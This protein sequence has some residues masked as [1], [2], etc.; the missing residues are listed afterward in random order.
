MLDPA[1]AHSTDAPEKPP[2][3]PTPG[4]TPGTADSGRPAAEKRS[5]RPV[6]LAV[7]VDGIP[8]ELKTITCWVVWQYIQ[9]IDAET[10]E[11]DYDK[12]PRNARTGGLA[13]STNPKSWSPF[14]VALAAY[15]KEGL[16][17]VGFVLHCRTG[18]DEVIVAIDLDHCRDPQSGAIELWA[19]KVIE[20]I[21]SYTEVSPSGTGIR[22]FLRGRR[23]ERG[24]KKGHVEVYCTARYVTVTG[25]HVEGTPA[26]VERRPEALAAF[27]REHFPDTPPPS[28]SKPRVE[29]TVNLDDAEI[30]RRAGE[31]K[32]GDKFKALWSGSHG[33]A[34][35][36]EADLALVNYLAFWCGPHPERIDSLFRQSGLFRSKWQR[37]DYRER[38][39]RKALEGRTEFFTG[40]RTRASANGGG[41]SGKNGDKA[42]RA[43]G[44]GEGV[45][46]SEPPR[47]GGGEQAQK[48]EKK[49][50]RKSAAT[51]LV[52]LV[53]QSGAELFHAPDQAAYVRVP[54]DGHSEVWPLR[55]RGFRAWAK[56]LYYVEEGKAAG[57]QALED[58][59]GILEGKALY[60][61]PEQ[62]VHVRVAECGGR[63]YLDLADEDWRVVE[64]DAAGWRL[65]SDAPVCF[66]R[67]KGML[68][69][70]AP[71]EGGKVE[72]LRRYLNVADDD[73]FRL[74]VTWAVQA[75][76]GR[77]PYPVLCLTG[78]Q[79]SAKSTNVRALRGLIDPNVAGLRSEPRE[80]R[81]LAI[82]AT[83][84]WLVTL[85][86]LSSL[87]VWLSDALCRLATGGGFATRQLYTDDEEALFDAMRPTVLNGIEDL[88]TRGDLLERA[89]VLSLPV[90]PE[91]KRRPERLFWAEY[92]ADRPRLLGAL[93]TAL[94]G[95]LR[96]LPQVRLKRLPRMADF[97]EFAVAV[98]AALG[99]R[100]GA[101]LAA[102]QGNR[103][104]ANQL[105]LEVC[106][107]AAPVQEFAAAR[108]EWC[109]KASDL[110]P[111]LTKRVSEEVAKSREW[112]KKGHVLSGK[113]RRLA[114]NL[115]QVGV[116]VEFSREDTS[117]RTRLITIRAVPKEQGGGGA[118][119]ASEAS[120]GA[121][122][123]QSV[124]SC[125]GDGWAGRAS[126]GASGHDPESVQP[127][128]SIQGRAQTQE[129]IGESFGEKLGARDALDAPPPSRPCGEGYL[130]GFD[131]FPD[132]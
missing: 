105:A 112:P 92:E 93:L 36:S 64:I 95:A 71:V 3:E 108:G 120:D 129:P 56:R 131:P 10:G 69:L 16:D 75:L 2:V 125:G 96:E 121:A 85:D 132:A 42:N 48:G 88:A 27:L 13:S 118:S 113:L 128:G 77:G 70:P 20:A 66:R 61:G 22:I 80:P 87:P 74:A 49:P 110:L 55:S 115:R 9:E 8:A 130:D 33:F 126:T 24:R 46:G 109:G 101:F 63:V 17:G 11:V 62:A 12:P 68:P 50:E 84:G 60:D 58:A 19:K 116:A 53:G 124:S 119:K 26:G 122:T 31:A 127:P 32:N 28:N 35:H 18:D 83:N 23:L 30:I 114:P 90:I 38:T 5:A 39:L 43:P 6:P 21:N 89:I 117:A 123:S 65:V 44:E 4:P 86:N 34:S 99:W 97:A 81:D 78:Q 45:E 67:P 104:D 72:D 40:P 107:V 57:G 15:L 14:G 100:Q 37:D 106:P 59:L 98:E 47:D 79:G 76:R 102:Y 1:T 94:S 51:R 52:E 91:E 82:A 73:A 25:Q 41:D 54:R 7:L 103:A 111:E 29:V